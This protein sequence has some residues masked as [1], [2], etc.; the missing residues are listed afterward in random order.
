METTDTKQSLISEFQNATQTTKETAEHFLESANGDLK[1]R[2]ILNNQVENAGCTRNLE[3]K[4]KWKVFCGSFLFGSKTISS[5]SLLSLP[6][7]ILYQLWKYFYNLLFSNNFLIEPLNEC[8]KF[9]ADIETDYG[10]GHP[11][12]FLGS[13]DD[14]IKHTKKEFKFLLLYIHS[15]N[16]EL[17]D[18]FCRNVLCHSAFSSFCNENLIL[19]GCDVNRSEGFKVSQITKCCGFPCLAF[20]CCNNSV[21][22]ITMVEK[23]EGSVD[24]NEVLERLT[25][26][27]AQYGDVLS[28]A[29]AASANREEERRLREQQDEEYNRVLREEQERERKRHEAELLE[30]EQKNKQ[31]ASLRFRQQRLHD[32]ESRKKTILQNLPVEPLTAENHTL[33][34]IKMY[35]GSR[36]QRRFSPLTT[37]QAVFDLVEAHSQAEDFLEKQISLVSNFPRRVY[38]IKGDANRTLVELGLSPQASF[39]VQYD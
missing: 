18:S 30:V 9:I 19:W 15:K 7:R 11:Q 35:D 27:M 2:E 12:F 4:E 21:G 13:Y 17:T 1:V 36:I 3:G 14:V 34:I 8:Q 29:K 26:M 10:S 32:W 5:S 33:V 23:I 16:H 6:V 39:F 24:V 22:G 28:E 25:L 20:L 37:M 31:E 38:T